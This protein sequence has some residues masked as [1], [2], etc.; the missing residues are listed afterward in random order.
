MA[1]RP[2][3]LGSLGSPP[4]RVDPDPSWAQQPSF[5]DVVVNV[6]NSRGEWVEARVNDER[7][8][9]AALK[10]RAGAS[11][12][13]ELRFAGHIWSNYTLLRDCKA[14]NL[15]IRHGA[16]LHLV[17]PSGAPND[18]VATGEESQYQDVVCKGSDHADEV[19]VKLYEE[20]CANTLEYLK[21]MQQH[22]DGAIHCVKQELQ[23]WNLLWMVRTS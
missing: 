15:S 7:D 14:N 13:D 17:A 12:A 3:P 9:V 10:L 4:A 18:V 5:G 23:S 19:R 11:L 20:L 22:D 2:P 16:T 21:T 6:R 1:F 8:T